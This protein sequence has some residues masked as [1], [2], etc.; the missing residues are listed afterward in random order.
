VTA[1]RLAAEEEMHTD[2]RGLVDFVIDYGYDLTA[3]EKVSLAAYRAGKFK[4]R[5]GQHKGDDRVRQAGQ[6]ISLLWALQDVKAILKSDPAEKEIKRQ[7][8]GYDLDWR[9]AEESHKL[10]EQRELKRKQEY[11][12]DFVETPIPSIAWMRKLL[13]G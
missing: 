5:R 2:R 1:W 9:A 11:G 12:D 8:R 10:F 6:T 3:P 13:H 4:L 7:T